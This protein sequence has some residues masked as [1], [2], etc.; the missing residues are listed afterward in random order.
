MS[1]KFVLA[2]DTLVILLIAIPI[3]LT[4]IHALHATSPD[5]SP[6]KQHIRQVPYDSSIADWPEF[7]GD[8]SRDG[9]QSADTQLSNANANTLIP[10]SGAAYT[11]TGQVMASLSIYQ[12][13]MYYP[14]NTRIKSGGN[15]HDVSTLYA[16]DISNG[17][18]LWSKPLPFCA[19]VNQASY[20]FSTPAITTGIVNGVATTEVFVGWGDGH[21]GCLYDFDGLAGT[22]I[23]T[24]TTAKPIQ[25]S[26]LIAST[27]NGNIIVVGANDTYIHAFSVDFTGSIGGKGVQLWDYSNANDPPPPNVQKYCQ[28]PGQSCSDA[29]WGSP[30]EGLVP[31]NG[32]VHHYIYFPVGAGVNRTGHLDA[33]DIDM[34]VKGHPTLAWAYW[35]PN[36]LYDNDFT[37]VEILTGNNGI[38]TRVF[39]GTH[40]GHMFSLD[41]LTGQM[42]FDFDTSAHINN[43]QS[44]IHSSGAIVTING[45]TELIFGAG[46]AIT[47]DYRSCAGGSHGYIWAIDALSTSSSGTILWQTPDFGGDIVSSPTI[48]NTGANAVMYIMGPWYPK[49]KARGDLLAYDPATGKQLADYPVFNRAY[50]STSSPTVYG[51][52]VFVGEGYSIYTSPPTPGGGIAAFQCTSC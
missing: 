19:Q 11:T 17:Q 38:A 21:I 32:V 30:A 44:F 24:F 18:V 31:V 45:T 52:Y 41:P 35:D 9:N 36:P 47:L 22:I 29:N 49:T 42:Y 14:A 4:S 20:S 43:V 8:A 2:L 27:S 46:C 15:F 48:A 28:I 23:W 12:G 13:I 6:L 7:R 50:G 25:S 10:V 3:A 33:L 1:R 5:L 37:T 34:M 51:G 40:T 39:T 26:P 16:V